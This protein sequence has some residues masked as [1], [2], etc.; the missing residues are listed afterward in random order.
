M[1]EKI[2]SKRPYHHGDLKRVMIDTA[3]EM[4][5]ESKGWQ[6]TLR[7]I[8]RRAEV[9]HAAPYKHFSDKNALLTEL[10]LIG[11]DRLRSELQTALEK[12]THP[13]QKFYVAGETYIRFGIANPSL[14]KL[15]FSMDADGGSNKIHLSERPLSAIGILFDIL[16]TGQ[17]QEVFKSRPLEAQVAASWAQVHGLTM[18]SIDGLLLEEKVGKSAVDS[19]LNILL[20]GI[21]Q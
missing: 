13:A 17:E 1:S 18:L 11:F 21:Q 4:L 7:E 2:E 20:E 5:T 9:S 15:M 6:F 12:V 19:A 16:K 14:F 3:L 8:A 10:A